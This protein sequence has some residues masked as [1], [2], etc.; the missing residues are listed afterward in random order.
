MHHKPL[1]S[2]LLQQKHYQIDMGWCMITFL[3]NRN[4][5]LLDRSIPT[6]LEAAKPNPNCNAY[7]GLWIL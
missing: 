3:T 4:L 7:L 5:K 1:Q 2:A 6:L